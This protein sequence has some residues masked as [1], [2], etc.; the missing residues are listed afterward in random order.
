MKGN[1]NVE[2]KREHEWSESSGTDK[3]RAADQG[4]EEKE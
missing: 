2:K 1:S 4:R 3:D